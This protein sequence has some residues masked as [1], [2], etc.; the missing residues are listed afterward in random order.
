MEF[1]SLEVIKK[2][3]LLRFG[4]GLLGGLERQHLDIEATDGLGVV[5]IFEFRERFF[6]L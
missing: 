1:L 2:T 5:E 6:Q 3:H 4:K